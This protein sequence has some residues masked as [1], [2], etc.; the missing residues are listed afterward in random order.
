PEKDIL[1][2]PPSVIRLV[3]IAFHVGGRPHDVE[4]VVGDQYTFRPV[5]NRDLGHNAFVD[6]NRVVVEIRV[7]RPL[8]F[9]LISLVTAQPKRLSF[10]ES[11]VLTRDPVIIVDADVVA[12]RAV[13]VVSQNFT[14]PS[15]VMCA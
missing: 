4:Y 13:V 1:D 14:E 5:F 6:K 9:S 3:L 10:L 12:V 7:D 15:R 2:C 8:A 11:A